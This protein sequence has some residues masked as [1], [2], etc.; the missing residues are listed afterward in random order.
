MNIKRLIIEVF[1]EIGL[2][3]YIIYFIVLLMVILW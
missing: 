3:F 2:L 1:Q